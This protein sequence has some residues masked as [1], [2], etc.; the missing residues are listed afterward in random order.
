M[1]RWRFSSSGPLV[2]SHEAN[3]VLITGRIDRFHA[4]TDQIGAEIGNRDRAKR[5]EGRDRVECV[6]V[7]ADLHRLAG[8]FRARV[9]HRAE[10][11]VEIN[12]DVCIAQVREN[13]AHAVADLVRREFV[14]HDGDARAAAR[15]L[16]GGVPGEEHS[17]EVDDA[18][19]QAQQDCRNDGELQRRGSVPPAKRPCASG[20]R[21]IRS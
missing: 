15:R 9:V 21:H 7:Q 19:K 11:I 12:D 5:Q 6:A 13:P 18:Q 10:R 17:A 20:R 4:F 16:R 2:L 14:A 3:G 8:V 1:K